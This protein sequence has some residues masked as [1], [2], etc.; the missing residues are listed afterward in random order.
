MHPVL[1]F[2]CVFTAVVAVGT[3]LMAGMNLIFGNAQ[4]TQTAEQK[5]QQNEHA[6]TADTGGIREGIL[7]IESTLREETEEVEEQEETQAT[8]LT[9]AFAGDILLDDNY[10]PMVRLK[11]RGGDFSTC[12]SQD[13]WEEMHGADIFVVNNEF[14]FSNRGT[15]T[16][17]KQFTFR[18]RPESVSYLK[19]M[20]ADLVSLANNH[21]Y[22]YGEVSLTDTLDTLREAGMPYIGAGRNLE[23]ASG[24][25]GY[26]AG[27]KSVAIIAATQIERQDNPDTKGAADSTP[28]VFRCWNPEKLY[29]T[30]AAAKEEHDYVIV[31]IHWGTEN[32][33]ELDWAQKDQAKGIAQAGADL[34]IGNHPHCLQ[35]VGYVENVPVIYSLSNY[36]F[37][38]K[39]VDTCLVKV[40]F[41][42]DGLQQLQL[43]PARQQDCKTVL[44]SGK[45]K[46]SVIAYL[47]GLSGT[48]V[49][50]EEGY[51]YQRQ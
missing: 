9:F 47:N 14:T 2:I 50:D 31:Y 12:F 40:T 4:E 22:D 32:T 43:L 1:L 20:G 46:S 37:N 25:A 27:G 45:E 28:G 23:E 8:S 10:A 18:A 16:Q 48:A 17:D 33:D 6:D 7:E 29:E 21:A 19:D 42:K 44:L 30:I 35:E 13:L 49:L 34:I 11:Q 36:W 39:T 38:S 5:A 51:I 24:W 3:L 26:E 41:S 15:P